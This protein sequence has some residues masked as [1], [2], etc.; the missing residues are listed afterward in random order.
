MKTLKMGFLALS[1]SAVSINAFSGAELL[2]FS[3]NQTL[4]AVKQSVSSGVFIDSSSSTNSP[5]FISYDDVCLNIDGVQTS[6][7][8]GHTMA[9]PGYCRMPC[10]PLSGTEVVL[11]KCT[12]IG[13]TGY[14][15][16][17]TSYT[18]SCTNPFGTRSI[19][20]SNGGTVTQNCVMKQYS[21]LDF[22][23]YT[24][25]YRSDSAAELPAGS[26]ATAAFQ[27][28]YVDSKPNAWTKD[29]PDVHFTGFT[30]YKSCNNPYKMNEIIIG[31]PNSI[32]GDGISGTTVTGHWYRSAVSDSNC[33]KV[34]F[35]GPLYLSD[36]RL[37]GVDETRRLT[38]R[39][40]NQA[41]KALT[42]SANGFQITF[43]NISG[44][45]A[46]LCVGKKNPDGTYS[47]YSACPGRDTTYKTAIFYWY[48][49][50]YTQPVLPAAPTPINAPDLEPEDPYE[51]MWYQ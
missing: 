38:L 23:T 27:F 12:D 4:D 3:A 29:S 13:K 5:E 48:T 39:G 30:G 20:E 18:Q 36:N 32:S 22:R 37:V 44:Q 7:P 24:T 49:S 50:G 15:T 51:Y 16:Y 11:S 34:N 26:L 1:L 10:S 47:H 6:V 40:I 14:I 2:D 17:S 35:T 41:K 9:K 46:S 43:Y 33:T 19:Y 45:E 21:Q 31:K 42:E 8:T 28:G 25:L